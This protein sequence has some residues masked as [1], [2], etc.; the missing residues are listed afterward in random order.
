MPELHAHLLENIEAH[1]HD[2]LAS[3]L[4]QNVILTSGRDIPQPAGFQI[5]VAGRPGREHLQASP[6][7]QAVIVPWAGIPENTRSLLGEFPGVA[8]HNLHH[9]A[10]MTAE[11]ALA[12]L[13]AAAKH[14]VPFDQ[15]L[16][17][18]DWSRRY[19]PSPAVLLD[20]KTALVLG[21]G[22][23]GQRVGRAC[24]A[25]GMNVLGVRRNP[26]RSEELGFPAEVHGPE[27]LP[28]LFEHA[29]V[30]VVTL[31]ATPDTDG[32][33]GQRE[34]ERLPRGALLVNVGRGTVVDQAAL[35][36]AL[37]SGRL[38]GAGLDVWYHYPEGKEAR[39]N[40]PPA[41]YPFDELENVVLSPHRAG[42]AAE[43]EVVRMRHL[44]RSINAAADGQPIPNRVDLERGY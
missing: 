25:M 1:L 10:A 16:R 34:L 15:D 37:Q 43:S 39:A 31:P 28:D 6:N 14:I 5:L 13:L 18:N 30:L 17:R 44:A 21:F 29:H 8:L 35:Y 23:I 24:A 40:T 11:T 36:E 22:Q 19:R 7:L 41:D 33:I 27:D 38:G 2:L 12:L 4:R 9:N 26:A 42:S 20:G 3:L 32:L